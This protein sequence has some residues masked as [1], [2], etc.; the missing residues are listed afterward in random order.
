MTQFSGYHDTRFTYD[1]RRE[2][3]WKTLCSSYFQQLITEQA[4]V[5]E[6]GAGYGHFINNIHCSHKMAID[7]WAGMRDY[8]SPDVEGHIGNATDLS[9]IA[10]NSVDFVFASNFFEHMT[11][12]DFSTILSQL[13]LKLRPGG[14]LNIV[15]PNFRFAYR[16][17]FDDYTHISIY[18]DRS[19]TDFLAFNGF[20][21]IECKP[22]FLPLTL[23]SRIP[24]SPLLISMYLL[25]PFKPM[26]KQML[27]RAKVDG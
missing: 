2:L 22:R 9:C 15:Q 7:I 24:V 13:R 16:E 4:S 23:K 17:Y 26:G 6:L 1:Q 3:L 5:L 20:S 27:I 18:T 14:T 8:L 21:V 11:Q 12:Q 25:L 19:I 10:D